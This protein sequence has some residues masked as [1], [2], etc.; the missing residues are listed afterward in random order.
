MTACPITGEALVVRT[1]VGDAVIWERADPEIHV[2]DK[3]LTNPAA[4][5]AIETQ[6]VIGEYCP[7]RIGVRHARLKTE[8]TP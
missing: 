8:E 1:T 7:H 2:E 5:A 6:Y 3:L 4:R